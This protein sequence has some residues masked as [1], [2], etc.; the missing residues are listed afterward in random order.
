METIE[1]LN[2]ETLDRP[3]DVHSAEITSHE[4]DASPLDDISRGIGDQRLKSEA[5]LRDI[6]RQT[7]VIDGT[8]LVIHSRKSEYA[9]ELDFRQRCIFLLHLD[10]GRAES[11]VSS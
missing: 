9:A 2:T 4:S 8:K 7:V 6:R 3:A 11:V 1:K 10:S 5:K